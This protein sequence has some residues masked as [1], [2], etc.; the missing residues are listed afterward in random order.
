MR[1]DRTALCGDAEPRSRGPVVW[2]SLSPR[3][4][5]REA[6]GR[7]SGA[8]PLGRCGADGRQGL[9]RKPVAGPASA[10]RGMWVGVDGG[11]SAAPGLVLFSEV[12]K[13]QGCPDQGDPLGAL[14]GNADRPSSQVVAGRAAGAGHAGA[15]AGAPAG[16]PHRTP[17]LRPG[18]EKPGRSDFPAA[19]RRDVGDVAALR[20]RPELVSRL[21]L[22]AD[23]TQLPRAPGAGPRSADAHDGRFGLRTAPT[24]GAQ[25]WPL[26]PQPPEAATSARCP[27][28]P[29]GRWTAGL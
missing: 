14:A 7:I 11:A 25:L 23:L 15:T 12:G 6:A 28:D 1:W 3:A 20:G 27:S 2:W 24:S 4:G 8:R 5:A 9:C 29:R 16:P 21:P 26:P 22:P 18:L 10:P 19:R 13:P 17:P